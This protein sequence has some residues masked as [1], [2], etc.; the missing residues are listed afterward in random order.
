MQAGKY[1]R[2]SHD[3]KSRDDKL[4]RMEPKQFDT[5][6][7]AALGMKSGQL[8]C[9]LCSARLRRSGRR[10]TEPTCGT[11]WDCVKPVAALCERRTEAPGGAASAAAAAY[12]SRCRT[13]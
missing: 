11:A 6:E 9:P 5:A 12:A 4:A 2:R 10:A 7:R 3:C 8:Y 13:A 1:I